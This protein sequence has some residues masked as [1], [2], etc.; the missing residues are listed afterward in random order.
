[1]N[2]LELNKKLLFLHSSVADLI[3]DEGQHEIGQRIV[4]LM[5]ALEEGY[6]I[7]HEQPLRDQFQALVIWYDGRSEGRSEESHYSTETCRLIAAFIRL[8]LSF[9]V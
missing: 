7:D 1:M 3:V 8:Y 9:P 2:S 6:I 5:G 4:E